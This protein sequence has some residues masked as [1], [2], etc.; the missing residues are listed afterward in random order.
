MKLN[1]RWRREHRIVLGGGLLILA[2]VTTSHVLP[3]LLRWRLKMVEMAAE[4]TGEANRAR[5][6][7]NESPAT[8]ALLSRKKREFVALAP[9]F[10]GTKSRAD[11]AGSLA[12]LI[13]GTA[14]YSGMRIG[15]IQ[16]RADTSVDD[17]IKRVQARASLTGDVR[18]V[19]SLL[20]SLERGPELIAVRELSLNQPEP[21][22]AAEKPE[23]LQLEILVQGV[24]FDVA[25]A[26][27]R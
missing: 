20:H 18:G 2:L 26:R 12:A 27:S 16:I 13:S 10:L 8:S 14:Q 7:T 11:A 17:V 25:A 23:A 9:V 15:S 3:P 6:V 22:S 24:F 5:M 4:T 19:M 21:G 1:L